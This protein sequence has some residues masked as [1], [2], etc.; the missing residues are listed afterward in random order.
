[1]KVVYKGC[2]KESYN[3]Q[4]RET[5]MRENNLTYRDSTL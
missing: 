2:K 5:L 3:L 1:M 4:A